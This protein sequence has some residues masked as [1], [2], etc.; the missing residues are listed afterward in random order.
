MSL[1]SVHE[2]SSVFI[3][4]CLQKRQVDGKYFKTMYLSKNR[5]Q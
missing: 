4:A 2:I 1:E 5:D 3:D